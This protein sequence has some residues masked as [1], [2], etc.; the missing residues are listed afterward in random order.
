M[1]VIC[2]GMMRSGST[3]QYQ[4]AVSILEKTGKGT[5]L[6]EIRHGNCS[7]LEQG[8]QTGE[9]QVI[10]V[11]KLSHLKGVKEAIGQ[12]KATG[13]YIFRDIR[14]VTVSLMKMRKSNFDTL[15]FRSKEVQ[16]CLDD[17]YAW[18][19][20]DGL[21]ISRYETMVN[22][23]SN[24]V[25]RIAAHLKIDL[26]PREIQAIAEA[27]TIDQQKDRIK[28]WKEV[29]SQESQTY[30]PKTLL[31]YN[32]ISSGKSQQWAIDLTSIQIGYLET[33]AGEWLT[34]QDYPLSQP[35]YVRWTSQ[36][37]FSKYKFRRKV[38]RLSHYWKTFN[39]V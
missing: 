29:S 25:A 1:L 31:H 11:H 39:H 9:I 30:E 12:G 4:L 24:E 28:T 17:F 6:G 10:K 36:L 14:D 13:I 37:V 23:L 19:S 16:Q 5:G 22:N 27:H 2:C 32:H 7:D 8:N 26:L 20:F 34:Q 18:T 21:L 3:L 33:I 35:S 38:S 15:I